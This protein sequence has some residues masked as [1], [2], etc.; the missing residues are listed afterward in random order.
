[1]NGAPALSLF[2]VLLALGAD[3]CAA[4]NL[5][6]E[7]PQV[8]EPAPAPSGWSFT[9]TP[10]LWL[11]WL[12]GNTTIKGHDFNVQ[13]DPPDFFGY[14][15]FGV[16]GNVE[17]RKGPFSIEIDGLYANLGDSPSILRSTDAGPVAA[18]LSSSASA[19]TIELTGGY[20]VMRWEEGG[21]KDGGGSFTA[22]EL[23]AGARYWQQS[24][25]VSL[26]LTPG[27]GRVPFTRSGTVD[28]TDPFVGARLRHQL[29]PGEEVDV[30]GDVGGFGAGSILSW[31]ALATYNRHLLD[32]GRTKLDAYLGFRALSVDYT[33][34]SGS[35]KYTSDVVQYGPVIG[36]TAHLFA[37]D[38]GLSQLSG[39]GGYKDEPAS[40]PVSWA[41]AYLGVNGGGAW[42]KSNAL[43]FT[44][45]LPETGSA[46]A[47]ESKG[48]FGG[49]QAGHNW[50]DAF[51]LGSS[52]V[53]GL[54]T[55]FQLAE[56]NDRFAR[57]GA[58]A[59]STFFTATRSI[60]D[61]GTLRGRIGYATGDTLLYA[62]GGFAYANVIT[63]IRL[64]NAGF[65]NSLGSRDTEPG[66]A[67]GGGAEHILAPNWSLK[68]EY[69]YLG[70]GSQDLSN[71][72]S[73][74]AIDRTKAT[75]NFNTLRIGLN[76]H[77]P[78]GQETLK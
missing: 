33:Q 41:G 37:A 16:M 71:I 7:Q 50:Q 3:T 70:L 5:P 30:R 2:S 35:S 43:I 74:G 44:D 28:W 68:L 62:T 47:F 56:I 13:A 49:L 67:L 8:S 55:D 64:D 42:G 12:S 32:F 75:N 15:K 63:K 69:L 40:A 24:L 73:D 66:Y 78:G 54:E 1:M 45:T 18:K 39:A 21:L 58:F 29:A 27:G 59:G 46:G 25:D 4:A 10:Y 72:A 6:A 34:G 60:D 76:F 36:F 23:L 22:L 65:T 11:P 38:P 19:T 51:G 61:L 26:D 9:F 57:A 20:E 77:I 17:A 48:A 52:W 14:L 31:Q 53:L